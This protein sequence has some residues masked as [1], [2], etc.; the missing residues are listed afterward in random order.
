MATL[1]M[2]IPKLF[3]D[4]RYSDTGM[5]VPGV[6]PH[7]L[8]D[9]SFLTFC[10]SVVE[11]HT[12][13][14]QERAATGGRYSGGDESVNDDWD[15]WSGQSQREY[16]HGRSGYVFEYLQPDCI[17]FSALE[18]PSIYEELSLYKQLAGEYSWSG[19]TA[20]VSWSIKLREQRDAWKSI[21]ILASAYIGNTPIFGDDLIPSAS[22]LH[23]MKIPFDG[24]PPVL[25]ADDED[26][27]WGWDDE[28][29]PE[30]EFVSAC[31]PAI[32]PCGIKVVAFDLFGTILVRI[33][34]S[35]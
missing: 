21:S 31:K 26:D 14:L 3:E 8:E 5:S 23:S 29:A 16:Q 25:R 7:H 24:D 13:H 12:K 10:G 18:S 34:T 27:P 17:D 28:P 30:F 9:S 15:T 32:P 2:C 6:L 4:T 19:V 20:A 33:A 1:R 35:P 22:A 11:D